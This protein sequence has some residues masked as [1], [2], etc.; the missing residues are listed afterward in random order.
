[1]LEKVDSLI[2]LVKEL[3]MENNMH[4]LT[5]PSNLCR[6]LFICFVSFFLSILIHYEDAFFLY[7][8]LYFDIMS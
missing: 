2:L 6:F 4:F 1:M 8:Q 3:Q 7:S 5:D